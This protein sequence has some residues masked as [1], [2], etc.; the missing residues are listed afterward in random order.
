MDAASVL[1]Q[2]LAGFVTL[3]D[4]G[5]MRVLVALGVSAGL[6]KGVADVI[7]VTF[8]DAR[9][10]G[11]GGESGLLAAAYGLGAMAGAVGVARLVRTGKVGGQ[12]LVAGALAAVALVVLAGVGVLAPAMFAFAFLG[13]GE[14]LLQLT[15]GVTIQRQAPPQVLARVFGIVEGLRMAAV[16]VGSLAVTAFV[17]W[18]DL[19]MALVLLA[20]VVLAV[21]VLGVA[22]LR[23][24]GDDATVVSDE[25]VQRLLADPVFADLPA[26]S[27]ERLA[28]SV[29]VLDVPAGQQ[30]IVEGAAGDR[31]Y[32]IADGEVD[33][34]IAG[35]FVRSRG[36]RESFGEI[37]LL[38]DVPR[39]ATVTARTAV[40]LLT[41]GRDDFL[42]AVTG[43]PRSRGAAD[44]VVEGMLEA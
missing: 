23:R 31:Y 1:S 35:R 2:V 40:R 9:L 43:H 34:T 20:G 19:G 28:R 39:T 6:V 4:A 21:V 3:R 24:H 30:V 17:T 27:T 26:P 41:V 5:R 32:L 10:S 33:V 7:F 22:R 36:P 37:A 8:A 25:L 12:F 15:S 16:A 29:E 11:G 18:A 44:Q 38:R 14:S 13:A 42:E